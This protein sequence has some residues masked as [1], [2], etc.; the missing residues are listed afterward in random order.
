ME[1]GF[2]F[3]QMA[4]LILVIM[5]LT[6]VVVLAATQLARLG[7]QT[8]EL[9]GSTNVDDAISASQQ[10][11]TSCMVDEGGVCV[12]TGSCTGTVVASDCP[13]LRECCT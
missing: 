7:A 6:I 1:K 5:G 13:T 12:A 3:A 10:T 2:T 4:T 11:G 9:G 8:T